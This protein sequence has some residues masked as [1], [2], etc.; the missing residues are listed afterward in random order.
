MMMNL[1]HKYTRKELAKMY[2]TITKFEAKELTRLKEKHGKTLPNHLKRLNEDVAEHSPKRT[3]QL[4][5]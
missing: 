2:P 3:T 5:N 1:C 4:K